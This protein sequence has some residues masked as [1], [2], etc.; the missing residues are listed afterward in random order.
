MIDPSVL[1]TLCCPQDHTRLTIAPD[2]LIEM[3]NTRI[4]A[5]ALHNV[6]GNLLTERWE[7]GLLR[8]DGARLYPVAQGIP[9][10][11]MDEAIDMDHVSSCS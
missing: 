2:S 4:A 7:G 9:R 1:S 5:G 8:T 10:L 3:L 6:A 11:V